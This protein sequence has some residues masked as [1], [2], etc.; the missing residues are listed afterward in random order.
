MEIKNTK[1]FTLAEVIIVTVII[2]VIAAFALP[3]YFKSVRKQYERRIITDLKSIHAANEVYHAQTRV[4]LPP[5]AAAGTLVNMNQ[6][7]EINVLA[8]SKITYSCDGDGSVYTCTG[9]YNAGGSGEFSILITQDPLAYDTF[10]DIYNPYC[11]S[12]GPTCPSLP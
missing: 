1:A 10:N 9:A 8:D 6:N 11:D 2:S 12:S 7:L 4:Y 5:D 3:N